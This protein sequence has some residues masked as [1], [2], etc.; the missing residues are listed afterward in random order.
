MKIWILS[1][2][3]LVYIAHMISFFVLL[4]WELHA[5]ISWCWIGLAGMEWSVIFISRLVFFVDVQCCICVYRC[6]WC[7]A[8]D[9]I[10]TRCRPLSVGLWKGKALTFDLC[11]LT[12][13]GIIWYC[14]WIT[15]LHFLFVCWHWYSFLSSRKSVY[16]NVCSPASVWWLIFSWNYLFRFENLFHQII[17]LVFSNESVGVQF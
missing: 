14:I 11:S 16:L 4:G 7:V 3:F 6:D 2:A 9:V 10:F 15:F 13:W 5:W 17:T 8:C 12:S 1:S